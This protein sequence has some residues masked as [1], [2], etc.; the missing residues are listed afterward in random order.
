MNLDIK[1][2]WNKRVEKLQ[3][4][5]VWKLPIWMIYWAAIRLIAHATAGKWGGTV[6]PELTAM[7]ALERWRIDHKDNDGYYPPATAGV[8]NTNGEMA[9]D[10]N[11]NQ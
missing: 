5:I 9:N 4:W 2:E 3:M 6:V 11:T 10:Q 1:Y 7:D 8:K